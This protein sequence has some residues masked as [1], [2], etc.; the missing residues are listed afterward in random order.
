M[1]ATKTDYQIID[2][3]LRVLQGAWSQL[4]PTISRFAETDDEL[5]DLVEKIDHG[6]S[7]LDR[8]IRRRIRT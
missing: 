2:F 6:I 8:L 5:H 7:D 1:T 4:S 3:G